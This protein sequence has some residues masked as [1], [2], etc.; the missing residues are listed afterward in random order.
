[1]RQPDA[2]WPHQGL[3]PTGAS[4]H[5]HQPRSAGILDDPREIS[6]LVTHPVCSNVELGTEEGAHGRPGCQRGSSRRLTKPEFPLAH[7]LRWEAECFGDV[8]PLEVGEVREDLVHGHPVSNHRYHSGHRH[9]KI[10]HAGSP[11]ILSGSTVTRSKTIPASPIIRRYSLPLRGTQVD[12]RPVI[13]PGSLGS[14]RHA[15]RGSSSPWRRSSVR[16]L[17]PSAPSRT[18]PPAT[19]TWSPK[20]ACRPCAALASAGSTGFTPSSAWNREEARTSRSLVG[21]MP[22]ACQ[23]PA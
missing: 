15:A 2:L 5:P 3:H 9:A 17:R 6:R 21:T 12:A 10:P 19:S 11:P 20:R 1:M 22:A 18:K 16:V 23:L 13:P 8:F 4:H 14:P 7:S